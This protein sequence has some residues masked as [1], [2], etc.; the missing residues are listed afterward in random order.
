MYE[1]FKTKY[2][3]FYDK[4][5]VEPNKCYISK[6]AF[7][8]LLREVR[9]KITECKKDGTDKMHFMGIEIGFASYFSDTRMVFTVV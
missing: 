7:S 1:I 5:G 9:I 3:E 2:Y 8:E 6:N 4:T